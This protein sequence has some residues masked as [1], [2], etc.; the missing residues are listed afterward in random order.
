MEPTLSAPPRSDGE[1]AEKPSETA[2]G[3]GRSRSEPLAALAAELNIDSADLLALGYEETKARTPTKKGRKTV[4]AVKL[5]LTALGSQSPSDW[6][7]FWCLLPDDG[8]EAAADGL[9]KFGWSQHKA[10]I[11]ADRLCFGAVYADS[12]RPV[13]VAEGFKDYASGHQLVTANN[14]DADLIAVPG[15]HFA[16]G[17][18]QALAEQGR[19][20]CL[21]LDV[22]EPDAN[23]KRSGQDATKKAAVLFYTHREND[24]Q[25]CWDMTGELLSEREDLT[26]WCIATQNDDAIWHKAVLLPPPEK[27]CVSTDP[28]GFSYILNEVLDWEYRYNLRGL[29]FEVRMP[30]ELAPESL[31]PTG[32]ADG[33]LV[34]VPV[35]NRMIAYTIELIAAKVET[36]RGDTRKPWRVS[37]EALVFAMEALSGLAETDP[38]RAWMDELPVW[39]GED[40]SPLHIAFPDLPDT[41]YLKHCAMYPL[42]ALVAR[43]YDPGHK[44]DKIVSL[45]G[46][47]GCGKDTYIDHLLPPA[48]RWMTS[49]VTFAGLLRGEGKD[50]VLKLH[51]CGIVH[52]SEAVGL[53]HTDYQQ[54]KTF[55]TRTTDLIRPPYGSAVE[56]LPR[57]CVMMASTNS[58]Q[59]IPYDDGEERRWWPVPLPGDDI[60]DAAIIEDR[61]VAVREQ[62]WAQAIHIWQTEGRRALLASSAVKAEHARMTA[63]HSTRSDQQVIMLEWLANPTSE[64]VSPFTL[65]MLAEIT[66]ASPTTEQVKEARRALT[67]LGWSSCDERF[68]AA[69][70]DPK[71]GS[72]RRSQQRRWVPPARLP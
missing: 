63:R 46:Q 26:T 25:R 10:P 36:L 39:D 37:K 32:A 66:D 71:D 23:G 21:A 3:T 53:Q 27:P 6:E 38:I 17:V 7:A 47:T 68:R 15:A 5:P 1:A 20:V 33:E 52:F 12:R 24:T 70:R 4:T 34:W 45:H 16:P 42:V 59:H 29:A 67:H 14:I 48:E 35:I 30:T 62:V 28:A 50:L 44:V 8:P 69:W 54:I 58:K 55:I 65:P 56:S 11:K 41:E 57:R 64:D 13:I 22:D 19:D 61:L 43:T 18:V 40:R 51:R 2:T 9:R 31:R 60:G 49:D 72:E